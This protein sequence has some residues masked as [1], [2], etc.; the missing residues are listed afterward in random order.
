[1]TAHVVP[2]GT[3]V[4]TVSRRGSYAGFVTRAAA[5]VIDGL[6]L[7]ASWTVSI[8]VVQ[9]LA[10]LFDLSDGRIQTVLEGLAAAVAG[11]VLILVYN[12]V[13]LSVFGK[14]VGMAIFGLRVVRADGRKPGLIRAA[15]RTAAYALSSILMLG[16]IWISVDNR[17]QGWHDKIARTFV[18]YDWETRR[19]QVE[20]VPLTDRIVPHP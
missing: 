15:V 9:A 18:V 19:G 16:F 4:V 17:R 11:L 20:Q 5:F 14:T 3:E 6:L 10:S 8:F 1:V 13:C 7:S 12:S 2:A